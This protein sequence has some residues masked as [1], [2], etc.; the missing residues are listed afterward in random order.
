MSSSLERQALPTP[1]LAVPGQ[2]AQVASTRTH[3]CCPVAWWQLVWVAILC[4]EGLPL[5]F[6]SRSS[7]Q[8]PSPSASLQ[9]DVEPSL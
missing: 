1:T 7:S 6:S 8:A 2:L 4:P 9:T 5:A 3:L